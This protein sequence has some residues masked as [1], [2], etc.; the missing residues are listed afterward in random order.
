MHILELPSFFPPYGGMFCVDQAKALAM[1]GNTVRIAACVNMSA[2]LS[3]GLYLKAPLPTYMTRVDGIEVMR[4]D[5]RGIPFFPK[6][7]AMHWVRAVEKLVD[8]YVEKFGKPD[9]IHAHCCQWAGY[10]AM[11]VAERYGVPYVVTE[12][13]SSILLKRE[14]GRDIYRAWQLPM[15]AEAY[16]RADLVVP[17]SAELVDDLAPFYGKDYKWVEVSNTIDTDFFKYK[18]R[19][20][21]SADRELVLCCIANFVP[22]K[23]YDVMFDAVGKYRKATGDRIRVFVAGRFTD[24][25]EA[26][27]LAGEC[28]IGDVV[29][30]YGEVGKEKVLD[31]LYRSDCMLLATRKEAQGLVVLEAMSTGLPV[32]TTDCVPKS[33]RIAPGCHIVPVDEAVAMARAIDALRR[34]GTNDCLPASE[35]V[36]GM[37]SP[38]V[39]GKR[40]DGLFR[41]VIEMK[42]S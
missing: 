23:G 9:I 2:R 15:I 17:V 12:H 19:E 28:G 11:K 20:P 25:E 6:A 8:K 30:Y 40:L 36:A 26:R 29:E 7:C 41:K 16:R 37:A 39:V 38:D 34:E 5:L 21:L 18:K 14:Y 13:L 31:I 35:S 22:G 3:P 33:V 1:Q 32:I 24:S 4:K 42:N 10:A 27:K